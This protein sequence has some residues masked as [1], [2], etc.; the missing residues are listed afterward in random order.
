MVG[1]WLGFF[2]AAWPQPTDNS[3]RV[4]GVTQPRIERKLLRLD[5]PAIGGYLL[6]GESIVS[7]P[8]DQSKESIC[9]V[10][11][12]LR[13]K[14][15]GKRILLVLDN[16]SAHTCEY[17]RK[18]ATQLGI[19]LVFLPVASPHL[20]PI[21]QVWR[22]LKWIISPIVADTRKEFRGVVRDA[23]YQLTQ[24]VSFAESWVETFLNL[25]KL[26]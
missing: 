19:D 14:N 21:E 18:R 11:E 12:Q 4:W 22:A 10:F 26:Y 8:E 15:P 20:N 16:F 2:D 3:Q 5:R 25:Q 9:G 1:Q 7:F 13:Q 23:F 6:N 24:R 17:T